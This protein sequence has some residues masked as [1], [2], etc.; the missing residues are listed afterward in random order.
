VG[1]A[2]VKVACLGVVLRDMVLRLELDCQCPDPLS[3]LPP[4]LILKVFCNDLERTFIWALT[5][6]RWASRQMNASAGTDAGVE[7]WVQGPEYAHAHIAVAALNCG[8]L[9]IPC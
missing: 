9:G 1:S 2:V 5:D 4:I 3:V 7:M 6:V 8:L